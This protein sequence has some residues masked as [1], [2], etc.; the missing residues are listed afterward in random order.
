MRQQSIYVEDLIF[1]EPSLHFVHDKV[2][3]ALRKEGILSWFMSLP[4]NCMKKPQYLGT[5]SKKLFVIN[6][7]WVGF[8]LCLISG[9][10]FHASFFFLN[11]KEQG[12]SDGCTTKQQKTGTWENKR[13]KQ[14]IINNNNNKKG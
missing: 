6:P 8:S 9:D 10:C 7:G 4:I 1:P 11:K 2:L 13:E 12:V 3:W 5:V 14:I